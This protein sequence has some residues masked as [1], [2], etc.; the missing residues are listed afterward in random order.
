MSLEDAIGY[1]ENEQ[2]GDFAAEIDKML[3][4]KTAERFESEKAPV[5]QNLFGLEDADD[6][7]EDD[8]EDE[9]VDYEDDE[10]YYDDE[11][12]EYDDEI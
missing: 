6:E 10:N 8:A 3:K 5:A 2:P 7:D 12:I 11:D 4:Q 1:V 9:V